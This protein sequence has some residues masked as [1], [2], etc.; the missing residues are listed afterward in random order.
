VK[1][2]T[3]RRLDRELTS[4]TLVTLTC[5]DSGQEALISYVT[6]TVRVLDVNDNAPRFD[7]TT[8]VAD[9]LENSFIGTF[10]TKV[11]AVDDDDGDSAIVRYVLADG[12]R[13]NF[14]AELDS[15]GGRP[16]KN[17]RR[18][19]FQ[20]GRKRFSEGGR[21]NGMP[22]AGRNRTSERRQTLET[23]AKS[24]SEC[25]G[26]VTID[27]SGAVTVA[28]LIDFEY[29]PVINCRILAVDSGSPSK[30]GHPVY[31]TNLIYVSD[32]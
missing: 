18:K 9:V 27:D 32:K 21:R 7:V 11:K 8:Y 26:R 31:N 12:P 4:D 14:A 2:V 15:G 17:T 25:V 30:T 19:I 1:L 23:R 13:R 3:A 29:S 5:K 22:V 20:D 6:L 10:V 24:N 28:G 16:R